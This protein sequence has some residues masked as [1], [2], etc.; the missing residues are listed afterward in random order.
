MESKCAAEVDLPLRQLLDAQVALEV[1][2]R[3]TSGGAGVAG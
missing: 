1:L 2:R 3:G